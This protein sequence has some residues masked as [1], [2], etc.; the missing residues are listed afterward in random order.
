MSNKDMITQKQ[1]NNSNLTLLVDLYKLSRKQ[2]KPSASIQKKDTHQSFREL[3]IFKNQI[4]VLNIGT[5]FQPYEAR[6]HAVMVY[7]MI[8]L[9]LGLLF[10]GL[11]AL[12][13]MQKMS[14][15]FNFY[16]NNWLIGKSLICTMCTALSFASLAIGGTL[17]VEKEAVHHYFKIAKQKLKRISAKKQSKFGV[18]A[19]IGLGQQGKERKHIKR[20]HHEALD[21]IS[22]H[23]DETTHLLD[24]ITASKTLD[25]PAKEVL[26]NQAILELKSLLNQTTQ[27]FENMA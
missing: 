17:R 4:D 7:R 6:K 3:T 9:G 19:F 15:A 12:V 13:I 10:L 23:C 11:D 25:F 27:H 8:F 2:G 14:W 24:R 21:K 5:H 1:T 18:A 16:F 26:Y 22:E 20:T